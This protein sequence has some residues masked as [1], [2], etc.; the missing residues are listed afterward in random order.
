MKTCQVCNKKRFN[1]VYVYSLP[2]PNG[3]EIKRTGACK[4]C[5]IEIGRETM[6]KEFSEQNETPEITPK[7]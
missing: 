3:K 2:Y 5:L 7:V 6:R 1:M 4:K